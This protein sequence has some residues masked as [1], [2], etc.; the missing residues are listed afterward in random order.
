M[1]IYFINGYAQHKPTFFVDQ[2]TF[3]QYAD[4]FSKVILGDLVVG[5]EEDAQNALTAIQNEAKLDTCLFNQLLTVVT[6]NTTTV[7]PVQQDD[8]ED[9]IIQVFNPLTG[10][11][12]T[13]NSRTEANT[14][15]VEIQ[16]AYFEAQNIAAVKTLTEMPIPILP[17]GPNGVPTGVMQP[18]STGTQTV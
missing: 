17:V 12:T 1:S 8:Q 3:D 6:G 10:S 11:Y 16:K 4:T 18:K 14:A 7:R 2:T 9:S 5:T 15:V 13:Y